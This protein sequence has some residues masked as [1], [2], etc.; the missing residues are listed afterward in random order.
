MTSFLELIMNYFVEVILSFVFLVI[1]YTNFPKLTPPP[2][3]FHW[4]MVFVQSGLAMLLIRHIFIPI[5][6]LHGRR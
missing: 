2:G 6:C 5:I 4:L 3:R 1:M